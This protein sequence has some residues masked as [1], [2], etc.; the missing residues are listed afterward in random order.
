MFFLKGHCHCRTF[1]LRWFLVFWC[2]VNRKIRKPFKLCKVSTHTHIYI[3]IIH[4]FNY[5]QIISIWYVH[6]PKLWYFMV[7]HGISWY[8]THSHSIPMAFCDCV[9]LNVPRWAKLL[10]VLV[11]SPGV[12]ARA[13]S[14]PRRRWSATR[15]I[16]STAVCWNA[17]GS[18]L[19]RSCVTTSERWREATDH[20]IWL[21]YLAMICLGEPCSFGGNGWLIWMGFFME[22]HDF[23]AMNVEI[24]GRIQSLCY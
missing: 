3:Y 7:F 16:R 24:G 23:G 9:V 6:P 8:L 10:R 18:S 19:R 4:L 2:L 11:A 21:P 5:V 17:L 1:H 15:R 13:W 20:Q 14:W 12:R 22:I